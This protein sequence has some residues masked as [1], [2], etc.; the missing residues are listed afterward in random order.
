MKQID[1]KTKGWIIECIDTCPNLESTHA[2]VET[3]E[4]FYRIDKDIK[5]FEYFMGRIIEKQKLLK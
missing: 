2:I 4:Y 3:V 1:S 5:S